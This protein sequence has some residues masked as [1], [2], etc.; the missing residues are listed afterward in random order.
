MSKV[1][2]HSK[3][4]TRRNTTSIVIV[5]LDAT[6]PSAKAVDRFLFSTNILLSQRVQLGKQFRGDLTELLY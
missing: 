1:G 3:S 5:I 2:L 6:G 4:R